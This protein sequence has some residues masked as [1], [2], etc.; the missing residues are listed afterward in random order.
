[1]RRLLKLLGEGGETHRQIYYG[2]RFYPRAI[3]HTAC[4]SF[5]LGALVMFGAMLLGGRL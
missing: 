3:L 2:V 1:M 5:G 4:V